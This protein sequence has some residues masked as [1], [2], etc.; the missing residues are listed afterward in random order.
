VRVI[1][2]DDATIVREGLARLL[3]DRGI[4]IVAQAGNADELLEHVA[5]HRPDVAVIDIRMPPTFTNEGL[6]AA[7]RIRRDFPRVATVVLSQYIE[8]DY[9]L[10]LVNGTSEGVGYLLKDRVA[11]VDD[12]VSALEQVV[13][14]G[15]VIE[16]SLVRELL[17]APTTRNPLNR[18]T[19]RERDVLTLVAEGRT[20]RGIAEQLY[21]TR[22]TV[23]A[24]VRSILRKL[25]LPTDA[26]ENRR[27]HA[28][29]TYLRH[30][31]PPRTPPTRQLTPNCGRSDLHS[32]TSLADGPA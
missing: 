28:V 12:L 10:K 7:Q 30:T 29:L 1:L 22:K 11:E 23:E 25:D 21:V 19:A 8:V 24:H 4:D 18:L 13:A 15:T 17:D 6:L 14:G 3:T 31:G 20:D 16:P 2:A 27:V 9:A 5:V 26:T 32:T